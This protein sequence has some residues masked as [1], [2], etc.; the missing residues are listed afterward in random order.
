MRVNVQTRKPGVICNDAPDVPCGYVAAVAVREEPLAFLFPQNLRGVGV[1]I[2][3][4]PEAADFGNAA[5]QGGFGETVLFPGF[6][7][8][9]RAGFYLPLG[10]AEHGQ[11]QQFFSVLE[12]SKTPLAWRSRGAQ[13]NVL[14][15]FY[16]Q[17]CV[18]R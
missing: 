9:F 13:A 1:R 8:G 3:T 15:C 2:F 4:Q 6:F 17:V 5:R 18:F 16:T 10:F 12:K 11:G 14:T 7:K